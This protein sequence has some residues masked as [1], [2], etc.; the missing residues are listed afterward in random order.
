MVKGQQRLNLAFVAH[1]FNTYPALKPVE[2]GLPD[3]DL[4]DFGETREEKSTFSLCDIYQ[5]LFYF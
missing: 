5:L 3:F 2:E 4:G 1:L